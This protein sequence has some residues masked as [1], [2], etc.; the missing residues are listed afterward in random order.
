MATHAD[1]ATVNDEAGL[2]TTDQIQSLEQ[3]AEKLNEKIKG[4]VL[5]VTTTSNSEEPRDFAD[6]YL[7]D[8]VGN[9]QN[10]SVLLLDMGQRE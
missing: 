2:F 10:G 1:T 6:N 4:R 9:D 3:Q 5:I 8:A 7:R